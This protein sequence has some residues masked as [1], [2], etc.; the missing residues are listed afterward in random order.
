[1]SAH[2]VEFLIVGA[3]ALAFHGAPRFTGDLDVW[4]RPTE[5]NAVR[6]LATLRD[7]GFPAPE[8]SAAEVAARA[9]CCNWASNR[10][11]FTS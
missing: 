8:L 6:L 2:G 10:C 5:S 9:G 4:I 1:L 11:R 3:C 7:F